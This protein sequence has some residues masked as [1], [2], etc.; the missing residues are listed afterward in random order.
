MAEL[1]AAARFLAI[2]FFTLLSAVVV[3]RVFSSGTVWS[4]LMADRPGGPPVPDRILILLGTLLTAFYW[5]LLLA[6][7]IKSGVFILPELSPEMVTA[8][9][10][11]NVFL[12]GRK[13]MRPEK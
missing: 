9:T 2:G 6:R 5:L 10:G 11:G 12:I 3:M 13:L 1:A 8:L 4:D 7:G